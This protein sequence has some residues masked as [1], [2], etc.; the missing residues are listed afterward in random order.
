[1][2]SLEPAT[3]TV[4]KLRPRWQ[5]FPRSEAGRRQYIEAKRQWRRLW[6]AQAL[7]D[8]Q[9]N[10][11]KPDRKDFRSKGEWLCARVA[12]CHARGFDRGEWK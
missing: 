2:D 9:G 12:Y 4:A 11:I 10:P 8:E 7:R 5:D 3:T 1:M 6:V